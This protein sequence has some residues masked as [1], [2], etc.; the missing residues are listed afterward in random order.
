MKNFNH[1]FLDGVLVTAIIGGVTIIA[2]RVYE[3]SIWVYNLLG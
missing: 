1:Y 3:L 2:I